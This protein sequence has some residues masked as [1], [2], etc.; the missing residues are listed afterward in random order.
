[1]PL[2]VEV[3][4]ASCDY[5]ACEPVHV[6]REKYATYRNRQRRV[7]KRRPRCPSRCFPENNRITGIAMVSQRRPWT[8][9][10][11][12]VLLTSRLALHHR[13]PSNDFVVTQKGSPVPLDNNRQAVRQAPTAKDRR[14]HGAFPAS[15][16]GPWRGP[17]RPP[18][19]GIGPWPCAPPAAEQP[20]AHGPLVN[21]RP[22]VGGALA[23]ASVRKDSRASVAQG[24]HRQ[25]QSSQPKSSRTQICDLQIH[26]DAPGQRDARPHR[27]T[28]FR[29]FA[30][31]V[32]PW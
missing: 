23:Q 21:Q 8:R 29:A 6:L 32:P 15:S 13:F 26:P 25:P 10:P 31:T 27:R 5:V 4:R 20:C 24:A 7:T 12:G 1:M 19:A 17:R 14:I 16:G 11:T 30:C 2:P 3:P 22:S 28:D 9:L 18:A